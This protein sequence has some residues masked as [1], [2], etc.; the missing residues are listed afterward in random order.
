MQAGELSCVPIVLYDSLF[1][2]SLFDRMPDKLFESGTI[3]AD[4]SNPIHLCDEPTEIA[5]YVTACLFPERIPQQEGQQ[6]TELSFT[7]RH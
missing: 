7:S 5:A 2:S 3:D 4:A 1:W 6:E